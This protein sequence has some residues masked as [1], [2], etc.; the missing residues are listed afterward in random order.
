MGHTVWGVRQVFTPTSAQGSNTARGAEAAARPYATLARKAGARR[1]GERRVW[2]VR[3]AW[4]VQR[5]VIMWWLHQTRLGGPHT[6]STHML[7]AHTGDSPL[8]RCP[9]PSTRSNNQ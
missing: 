1:G 9:P 5:E 6:S 7:Q 2:R 4:V 8:T 3:L